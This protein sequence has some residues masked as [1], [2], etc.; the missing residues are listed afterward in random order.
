MLY[1]V[2]GLV[3]RSQSYGENDRLL[4]VLTNEG[5]IAVIAKGARSMKSKIKNLTEPFVY[6]NFELNSKGHGAA[7]IRGGSSIEQFYKLRDSLDKLFLSNY[8]CDVA[9]ELSGEGIDC[10]DMLRLTLNTLYAIMNDLRQ[11]EQI[12][13]V[14]E[15]RAAAISG[16]LPNISRCEGCGTENAENTYFDVMNGAFLCS[17]CLNKRGEIVKKNYSLMYDDVRERSVLIP[18]SPASLSAVRFSLYAPM[19]KV[20]SFN[21]SN[22]TD[23]DLFVKAGEGYLLH[24]LGHGFDSL[25]LYYSIL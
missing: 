19:E 7:W 21:L 20:F 25:D 18:L 1:T 11:K 14:F 17:D 13:A 8:I 3:I 5:K 9:Y 23:L 4:T 2:D 16:Y 15:L 24:H 12:K 10:S 6:A 22:P